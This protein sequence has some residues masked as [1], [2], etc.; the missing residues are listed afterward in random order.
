M[1]IITDV[2]GVL[3]NWELGFQ[4]WMEGQKGVIPKHRNDPSTYDLQDKYDLPDG[5]I[6]DFIEEF[7]IDP[8]FGK[9][10]PVRDSALVVPNLLQHK[11]LDWFWLSCASR[12]D[13]RDATLTKEMRHHNL[14]YEFGQPIEGECLK[15]RDSKI[16]ALQSFDPANSIF[17]EDSLSHALDGAELGYQTF[18]LAYPY[19]RPVDEYPDNLHWVSN[20]FDIW[21]EIDARV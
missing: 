4:N 8:S 20:W 18:L 6:L 11:D 10:L 19:N 7:N 5:R 2:D 13:G 16:N 17:I 21:E 3:L 15:I 14:E 12:R 9:L 1:N